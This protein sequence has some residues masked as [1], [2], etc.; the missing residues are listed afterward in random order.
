MVV[1]P[2]FIAMLVV[3]GV[4]F[5]ITTAVE[6]KQFFATA[7]AAT[8]PLRD[9]ERNRRRDLAPFAAALRARTRWPVATAAIVM[10]NATVAAIA[11]TGG[12]ALGDPQTL[13]EWGANFGPRTSNGE[14]WRLVTALFLHAGLL[15]LAINIAAIVQVGVILER[16]VGAV[17]FAAVYLAAGILASLMSL[18][19][20]PVA[21]SSGAS[22]AVSGIYGL[23]VAAWLAGWLRTSA[24]AI[25]LR[26]VKGLMPAAG[27]FMIYHVASGSA[28]GPLIAGIVTGLGCGLVLTIRIGDRTAPV[29][30]IVAAAAATLLI[31][32]GTAVPLRGL[33]DVR[34][35]IERLVATEDRTAATYWTAVSRFK[36][37]KIT[38][39]ALAELIDSTIVPQLRAA[40]LHLQDLQNVPPEHQPLV[41]GADEFF[42]L[43]G[44]SWRL[45]A[46]GLRHI[47]MR[48]LGRADRAEFASLEALERIRPL[49]SRQ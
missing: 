12:A 40:H 27:V 29:R 5:R 6:R 2:V 32:V 47:N 30:R 13:V 22:G 31:A 42:R 21:V 17:A 7:F 39:E 28:T 36:E 18:S 24:A 44:E 41:A 26:A 8:A 1:I 45:R 49:A 3:A 23:V 38:A 15:P 10:L 37:R 19:L 46:E 4:A 25:P 34:P 20:A 33:T 9:A 11:L 16:I 14:W 43:R 35:G 48:T